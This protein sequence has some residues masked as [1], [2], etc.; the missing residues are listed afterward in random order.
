MSE[1]PQVTVR[2]VTRADLLAVHRIEQA[3]FGQPWPYDAFE[4]LLDEPAFLVAERDGAIAGYAVADVT[5]NFGRDV[6]HL[7][8]IAV[9]PEA[10]GEGIGRRLLRSTLVRLRAQGAMVVKLEVRAGNDPAKA[11]YRSEGFEPLRRVPRYYQDGEDAV[12]MV[13]D[14]AEWNGP[15][16]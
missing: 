6:G 1:V 16:S 12:V 8:D 13:L 15:R 7:K 3:S 11:L 10:R 9:H 5:P 2:K 14:L 4:N